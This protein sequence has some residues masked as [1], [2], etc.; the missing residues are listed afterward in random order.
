MLQQ[1]INHSPDLKK[2]SDEGFDIEVNGGHLLVHQIPYVNSICEIKYGTI[3]TVL[4]FVTPNKVGRPPDHTVHFCGEIPF[5]HKGTPLTSIINNSNTNKLTDAITV[6]HFFSSKPSCGYY[7]DY[8][9]KISTYAEILASQARKLDQNVSS[10]PGLLKNIYT[11]SDVFNYPDTN[12]A[13]A[14]I[15]Y[16]NRKYRNKKI[17]IIGVGGTGSYILDLVSKTPVKEIHIYDG[18][19]FEIHNAFRAP[20]AACADRFDKNGELK[21][22]NYFYDAYSKMHKGMKPHDVYVTEHNIDEFIDYDFVFIS[23]DKNEV[24]SMLTQNL[25]QLGV[26]F[27]DVG[28]G[29]NK[30]DDCLIG[31]IRIT[32]V[33]KDVNEHIDHRIGSAEVQ[34]NEY[35]TN[36]Q[37][38]DLNCLN[39]TLAVIKWKK[40][41]GYYQDLKNEHNNLYFLN[42]GKVINEDF[43]A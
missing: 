27:I 24:R 35:S 12:S 38:A 10:K 2:L 14:E 5:D 37:I 15:E 25:V 26:P 17:A 7:L 23:V 32:M 19:V 8:Y 39:A 21:K 28:L 31:T 33:T 41:L 20:G 42:T 9:E 30:V 13:K 11:G 1:L 40:Y 34:E 29:V 4:N 36:I 6:N 18:D 22:V 3:V 16:L 43:K